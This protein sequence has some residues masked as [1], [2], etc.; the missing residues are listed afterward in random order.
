MSTVRVPHVRR[1]CPAEPCHA[2][3][4]PRLARAIWRRAFAGKPLAPSPATAMLAHPQDV[5]LDGPGSVSSKSLTSKTRFRSGRRTPEFR[6]VTSPHSCHPAASDAWVPAVRRHRQRRA[7]V[8]LKRRYQ[9]NPPVPDRHQLGAPAT[10]S[11]AS[12]PDR[13][14]PPPRE[15]SAWDSQASPRARASSP[16]RPSALSQPRHRAARPTPGQQPAHPTTPLYTI[17]R[18]TAMQNSLRPHAIMKPSP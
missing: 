12:T 17:S 6:Q 11:L 10:P 4:S 15:N 13:I 3:G 18:F 9:Q 2:G 16:I 8:E 7:P 5:P 14:P 1:V